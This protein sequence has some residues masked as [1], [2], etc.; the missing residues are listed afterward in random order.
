[1]YILS[2]YTIMFILY[3]TEVKIVLLTAS[4]LVYFC[5]KPSYS[6]V[7]SGKRACGQNRE[8]APNL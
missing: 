4:T 5:L 6:I 2:I 8:W 1:M 3:F 7:M